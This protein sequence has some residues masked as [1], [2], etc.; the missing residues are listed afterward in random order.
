[1]NKKKKGF[2]LIEMLVVIAIIA[3]L[4]SIIVPVVGKHTVKAS[5]AANAANLRSIKATLSAK[6]ISEPDLFESE[7]DNYS[8]PAQNLVG[9]YEWLLDLIYG[10]GS[11]QAWENER[12]FTY[13]ADENGYLTFT[14]SGYTAK[15]PKAKA[16]NLA[17]NEETYP[18]VLAEGTPMTV[19]ISD[20]G[21]AVTYNGYTIDHF[22][23]I[24]EDGKF[25]TEVPIPDTDGNGGCLG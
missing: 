11:G 15:T 16:I 3:I 8:Q 22:A 9:A 13:T 2:T 25:D 21:I 7:L 14:F 4:V 18:M 17:Q 23:D 20:E 24:A 10:S 5:A 19:F 6:M 12:F 1:M